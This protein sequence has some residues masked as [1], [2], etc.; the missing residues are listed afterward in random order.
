MVTTLCKRDVI[1]LFAAALAA[2]VSGAVVGLAG[3]TAAA[4]LVVGPLSLLGA[5]ALVVY[6]VARPALLIT[7]IVS[8]S[9][10][11]LTLPVLFGNSQALRL[12]CVSFLILG[13]VIAWAQPA[14]AAISGKTAL[15]V[16]LFLA[17]LSIALVRG[18][19]AGNYSKL[20]STT[21]DIAQYVALTLL[22]VGFMRSAVSPNSLHRRYAAIAL[23]PAAYIGF[24]LL[25]LVLSFWL[26][27]PQPEQES[28]ALG[29]QSQTLALL[30]IH[31]ER[32][33]LPLAQSINNV[34][35]VA[36]AGMVAGVMLMFKVSG[37]RRIGLSAAT[38][39]LIGLLLSDTRTA[40]I[41]SV[42][43]IGLL[44]IRPR[45]GWAKWV[46]IA[47]PASPFIVIWATQQL[48]SL[49]LIETLSRRGTDISTASDRFIIWNYAL[50]VIWHPN[51]NNATAY[52]FGWGANGHIASGAAE[53]YGYLFQSQKY[54]LAHAHNLAIQTVLDSGFVGLAVFAAAALVVVGALRRNMVTAPNTPIAAVLGL[55]VMLLAG[56]FT[57]VVPT[58][59][60]AEAMMLICLLFG[61]AIVKLNSIH[62]AHDSGKSARI[63]QL[64]R[65]DVSTTV[66]V[67]RI[68]KLEKRAES[69]Q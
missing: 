15:V 2:A 45:G 39:C 27:I 23:A 20:P 14:C 5:T 30:G 34:G 7:P 4:V 58:Y 1:T 54:H 16:G 6:L 3:A 10:V 13:V 36:A 59:I 35:V 50:E 46:V 33:Q 52:L 44:L 48:A 68:G 22:A 8:F 65:V 21:A 25:L 64:F 18:S 47:L 17:L 55:L 24:N 67:A 61:C 60:S 28:V 41:M 51:G 53:L 29:S 32:V 26:P 62:I 42:V 63:T 38:V 37:Y 43:I 31:L 49:G 9:L 40:L 69:A 12:I 57:E 19:L 56:G 11:I 66:P